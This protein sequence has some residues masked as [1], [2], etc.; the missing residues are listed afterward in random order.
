[1]GW[2]GGMGGERATRGRVDN[3]P[4]VG[5]WGGGNGPGGVGLT[6]G[7]GW[8]DGGGQRA[9]RGRV[10]NGPGVGGWG[11]NGPG[12]GGW[13]Q[14][15]LQGGP[16]RA[17]LAGGRGAGGGGEEEQWAWRGDNVGLQDYNCNTQ[18]VQK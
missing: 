15:A 10:D 16:G 11:G 1:M 3:G 9:W 8:G 5:K 6:M 7:L 18:S 14:R 2:G 4:G 17:G 13:I 12:G